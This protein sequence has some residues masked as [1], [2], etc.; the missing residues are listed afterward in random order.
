VLVGLIAAGLASPARADEIRLVRGKNLSGGDTR[1]ESRAI[2]VRSFGPLIG[3]ARRSG[4]D[5]ES[6][7]PSDSAYENAN[8]RAAFL[9]FGFVGPDLGQAMKG[10]NGGGPAVDLPVAPPVQVWQPDPVQ[11]SPNPE[12]ASM[13]LLGTALAGLAAA[14]RRQAGRRAS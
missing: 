5:V 1:L 2:V 3:I 11:P 8:A 7:R 14:R 9:R 12:P 4:F 6:R 13:L 10:E